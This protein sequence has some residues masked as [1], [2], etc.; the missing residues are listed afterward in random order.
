MNSSSVDY[1]GAFLKYGL[2]IGEKDYAARAEQFARL[3]GKAQG[4]IAACGI[5]IAGLL[6]FFSEERLAAV[7]HRQGKFG[8][9]LMILAAAAMLLAIGVCA[10]ALRLR[11]V[12][13]P[14]GCRAYH[15]MLEDLRALPPAEMDQALLRKVSQDIWS[16]WCEASSGIGDVNERKAAWL[17]A[18]QASAIGAVLATGVFLLTYLA[19]HWA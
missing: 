3:D 8:L 14:F 7:V 1:W 17:C 11:K 6:A 9:A 12:A 16:L 5:L 2:E 10:M 18:G 13:D 19:A 4:T 15:V